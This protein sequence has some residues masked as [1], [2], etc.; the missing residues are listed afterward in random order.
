MIRPLLHTLTL[1]PMLACGTATPETPAAPPTVTAPKAAQ[2]LEQMLRSN[3]Q[4]SPYPEHRA[5]KGGPG[6]TKETAWQIPLEMNMQSPS[7]NEE[8]FENADN[9]FSYYLFNGID[10]CSTKAH[11]V[12]DGRYYHVYSV[13]LPIDGT[14]YTTEVWVDYTAGYDVPTEA[15][16]QA[17]LAA[18]ESKKQKR[19]ELLRTVH[20]RASADAAAEELY[21]LGP[22]CHPDAHRSPLQPISPGNEPPEP[23]SKRIPDADYFGSRSLY[24]FYQHPSIIDYRK[25]LSA[26]E[27]ATLKTRRLQRAQRF[28]QTLQQELP[29]VNDQDSAM[30]A[31]RRIRKENQDF[32]FFRDY[33]DFYSLQNDLQY[34][35]Q[36][37]RQYI[38]RLVDADYF[39]S[40][41]LAD[42]II[43]VEYHL[44]YE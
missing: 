1:W 25:D 18:F 35:R 26:E 43:K 23:E 39:G 7:P 15:E 42:F 27:R 13:A 29:H 16:I 31:A 20:D 33:Y 22:I 12:V 41:D 9:T 3:L 19:V 34:D 21:K 5:L 4:Q 24:L 40:V 14:A 37:M 11:G 28:M 17:E 6:F 10:D 32:F 8:A 44:I 38:R 2:V 30:Q 36:G